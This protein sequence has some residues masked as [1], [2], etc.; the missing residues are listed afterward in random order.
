MSKEEIYKQLKDFLIDRFELPFGDDPDLGDE[1][2]LYDDGFIDSMDTLVLLTFLEKTFQ[3]KVETQDLLDSPI[4]TV[5]EI[6]DF[7][8]ARKAP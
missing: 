4:N 3:I 2:H 8:F 6:V 1:T 5:Q 7:V